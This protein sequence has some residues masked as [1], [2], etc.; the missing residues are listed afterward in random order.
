MK[1]LAEEIVEVQAETALLCQ[2]E[3]ACK[4]ADEWHNTAT[5]DR[6]TLSE[7]LETALNR[8]EERTRTSAFRKATP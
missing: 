4:I 2:S 5:N 8:L 1:T 7:A 3:L 6:A